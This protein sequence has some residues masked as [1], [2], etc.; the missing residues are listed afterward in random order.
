MTPGQELEAD[1]A[2]VLA[3]PGSRHVLVSVACPAQPALVDGRPV[4]C[5]G[6]D[7][8]GRRWRLAAT[9]SRGAVYTSVAITPA[10]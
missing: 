7:T 1:V 5:L 2:R 9:E 4:A 10:N 6:T 3:Q 8:A